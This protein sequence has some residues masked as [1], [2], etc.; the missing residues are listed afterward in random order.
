MLSLLFAAALAA[1]PAAQPPAQ[2][3][4]CPA[5]AYRFA[6]GSTIDVGA[7]KDGLRWRRIDG[8]T[9]LLTQDDKGNWTSTLGWTGRPDGKRIGFSDCAHGRIDFDGKPGKRIALVVRDTTFEGEGGIKLAGRLLMPEGNATAPIVV[10]VHGAE[11]TSARIEDDMQRQLPAEGVAAFVYDKRGTGGS[12][13]KYTQDFSVLANDAVAAVREARRLA[14]TRAGRVGFR[15]GSQGGWVAPL[16]ATR[17]PVDFVMVGYGLAVS[18]LDEDR[19]AVILQL[20]LKG[21]DQSVIDQALQISDAAAVVISSGFSQGIDA[22]DAVR[23]KY[24]DQPW[25]KDVYGNF[26]HV[27]LPYYGEELRQKG[28]AY[29]FGTPWHYDPRPVL[30]ELK[31]PQLWMLAEADIDAPMAETLRRLQ[32]IAAQGSPI[33]TAVFPGAEHGMTLF[34]SGADGERLST[35]YP[36]G[37]MRMTLDFARGGLHGTYGDAVVQAPPGN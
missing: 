36:E 29:I 24:R 5:G 8:A 6:D 33:T 34:E 25:Y 32:A 21:Y 4:Q 17:T 15:G 20:G 37:Y 1:T 22:F 2:P 26:T 9:G 19:E 16:A 31:T 28:Q 7:E 30:G 13:G 10:L 3:S 12:Q 11:S 18:V 14:G 23:I 35:R 27:M